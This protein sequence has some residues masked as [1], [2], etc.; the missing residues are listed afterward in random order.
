MQSIVEKQKN[1]FDTLKDT[2]GLQNVMQTPRLEKVVVSVGVGKVK[3]EKKKLELIADRLAKI[4]GQKASVRPAKKS[5]AQFKVR[6]GQ[7]SGY[8]VTLRGPRMVAFLDK[9]LNTTLPR[10]RDFRGIN[11]T[12]DA[13]GNY[14][15]GIKENVIFP[16]TADEEINNVFGMSITVVTTASDPKQARAYLEHLGF[17]FKK[18]DK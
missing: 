12:F 11:S 3:G 7:I 8:Q 15:L 1:T 9:L 5:I 13:M 17:P 4:T 18:E 2:C 14:T 16:E 10:T 6:E